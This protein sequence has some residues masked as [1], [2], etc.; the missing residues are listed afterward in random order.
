MN[1]NNKTIK[2]KN[3]ICSFSSSHH[4]LFY[5][6]KK[7]VSN[8]TCSKILNLLYSNNNHDTKSMT[9]KEISSN[10]KSKN[11]SYLYIKKIVL[12]MSCDGYLDHD[13]KPYNR[14][15][16]LS[17]IGRWFAICGNLGNISFQ[18][19]CIL[20]KVYYNAMNGSHRYKVSMYR[21]DFDE[22]YD[23]YNSVAS[24]IYSYR[25]I[26]KSIKM[27]TD[28]FLVYWRS[29][30][31]LHISSE[32]LYQLKKQYHD[33]FAALFFWIDDVS[34]QCQDGLK[35]NAKVDKKTLTVLRLVSP[36]RSTLSSQV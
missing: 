25:N 8:S 24:A 22:S 31:M 23:E 26:Q 14:K 1:K 35:E 34:L 27:L 19:L 2:Q 18:A 17:Q 10:L 7:V 5:Y 28:R 4:S 30:G 20:S 3:N 33:E 6:R 15:Y 12:E 9:I 13:D 16:R 11:K 21:K 32:I 29:E 36:Q